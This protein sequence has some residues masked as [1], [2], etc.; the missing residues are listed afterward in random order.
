MVDVWQL[1]YS[2]VIVNYNYINFTEDCDYISD[3]A[4]VGC[5]TIDNKALSKLQIVKDCLTSLKINGC[6]NVSDEG[7]LALEHLQYE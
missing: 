4:F 5:H 3:I 2:L 6:L 1:F 7:V